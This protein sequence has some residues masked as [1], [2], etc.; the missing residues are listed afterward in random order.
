[1]SPL[2]KGDSRG[3]FQQNLRPPPCPLLTKEG[4]QRI[5]SKAG[6]DRPGGLSLLGFGKGG[7]S[8]LNFE[9]VVAVALTS[10]EVS[11]VAALGNRDEV[12]GPDDAAAPSAEIAQVANRQ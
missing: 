2:V 4:N 12:V 3:F 1:M 10:R 7:D 11:A 6:G 5:S 9:R 8:D